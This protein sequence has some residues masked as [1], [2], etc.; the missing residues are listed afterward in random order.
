LNQNGALKQ[1]LKECCESKP[2]PPP[3]EDELFT[4]DESDETFGDGGNSVD[5]VL[6]TSVLS[7]V[8]GIASHRRTSTVRQSHRRRRQSTAH[9]SAVSTDSAIRQ[10]TGVEKVES[11]RVISYV[12]SFIIMF[13]GQVEGLPQ[14]F[15]SD[16]IWTF[17][18]VSLWFCCV[19]GGI[20]GSQFVAL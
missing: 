9:E 15:S 4:D 16:G 18:N 7:T 19:N 3:E 12:F 6:G 20:N 2:Q 10:L 14:L 1:L 11:G 8:S 13:L 17:R 5:N